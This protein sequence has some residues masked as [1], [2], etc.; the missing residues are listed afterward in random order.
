MGVTTFTALRPA[1]LFGRR[2][3]RGDEA[4]LVFVSDKLTEE[5]FLSEYV[6]NGG[7]WGWGG[8]RSRDIMRFYRPATDTDWK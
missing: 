7:P 6:G 3:K 8:F 5:Q 2:Y 1:T 4:H